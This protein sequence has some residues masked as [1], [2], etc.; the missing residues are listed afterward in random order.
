MLFLQPDFI[1]RI[2]IRFKN[3]TIADK[4]TV[5][6][7]TF[8]CRRRDCDLAFSNIFCWHF[9]NNMQY[10]IVDGCLVMRCYVND[11][12]SYQ[13][14]IAPP[15]ARKN[16]AAENEERICR[17]LRLLMEETEAVGN[18]FVIGNVLERHVGLLDR[19]FPGEFTVVPERDHFDYLYSREKLITLSGKKLQSKRNHVNTFSKLYPD[20]VYAE[21][22]REHFPLCLALEKR[23]RA[24]VEDGEQDSERTGQ[25]VLEEYRAITRAFNHWEE[26]GMR[27]G[28][29]WVDDELVAFTF[30]YPIDEE[31]FDVCVEKASGDYNGAYQVIN[32]DFVRHL[33]EQYLYINREDDLG[34]EG[35]RRSKLSYIPDILLEKSAAYRRFTPMNTAAENVVA[36]ETRLLW[37]EVFHDTEAFTDLY[38]RRVFRSEHNVFCLHDGHVVSALQTLPYRMLF[39]GREV[40]VAYIS[41]VCTHPLWRNRHIAGNLMHEAHLRLYRR[42]VAFAVLIP[43]EQG[44]FDWYGPFGYVPKIDRTPPLADPRETDFD[45]YDRLQRAKSVIVL[46]DEEGYDVIREDI[47]LSGDDYRLPADIRQGMIRVVNAR[48]ALEAY[49]RSH[50]DVC[51]SLR[52]ADDMHIPMNNTYYRICNGGVT[53]TNEPLEDAVVLSVGQLTSFC[54]GVEQAVMNLMLD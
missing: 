35:L 6:R 39:H 19:Q 16:D 10:A 49:A 31:T 38:F 17:A 40:P 45:T 29:V 1:H 11:G 33:P 12:W 7:Y 25:S 3:I 36:D 32:R 43:A 8:G 9:L 27:G 50:T 47:R 21:L 24:A 15:E 20:Y 18:R 42:G 48:A 46:H 53:Q 41:G 2:M 22:R 30:G 13:M 28:S 54:L 52:V 4:D 14:P 51:C 34:D 23:W 5:Q 37:S 26:L 44:L